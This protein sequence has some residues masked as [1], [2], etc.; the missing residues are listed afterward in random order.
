MGIE[1]K[2]ELDMKLLGIDQQLMLLNES[3]RNQ[4]YDHEKFAYMQKL[5]RLRD[6]IAA[7]WSIEAG[8]GNYRGN[9]QL[10]KKRLGRQAGPRIM[11]LMA[12]KN[13]MYGGGT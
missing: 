9:Q 1:P 4:P 12:Q 13:R 7:D 5:R 10:E 8:P 11:E 2:S 3:M 6:E